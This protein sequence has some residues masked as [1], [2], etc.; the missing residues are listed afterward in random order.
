MDYNLYFDPVS[1]QRPGNYTV[2]K[3]HFRDNLVI[4]TESQPI[5]NREYKIVLIGVPEERNSINVGCSQ[6]PDKV[7]V[8]LY[9]LSKIGAN[10][11]MADFGNLKSGK[12][13]MTR[14]SP[15]VML[16]MN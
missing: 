7:R 15:Y 5:V 10:I 13:Q 8:M 16:L 11:S 4:H 3:T 2:G 14:I 12:L 1:I 6:A 9:Q